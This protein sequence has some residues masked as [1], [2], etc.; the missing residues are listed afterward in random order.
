MDHLKSNPERTNLENQLDEILKHQL[1]IDNKELI[2]FQNRLI[3]HRDFLF[4]F[5][6]HPKAPPDNN[7]SER[8]IR[9]IKVKQKISGQ[10]KAPSG[11]FAFAVLRS[12]TDT[13]IKNRQNVVNS[14][15]VISSLQTD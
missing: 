1:P 10:F 11:G 9:N 6:Y 3:K 4:T 7:A 13:I 5:L 15:R 12:V 2:H 14:L 8:A